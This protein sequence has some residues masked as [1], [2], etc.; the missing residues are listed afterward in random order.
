MI[1]LFDIVQSWHRIQSTSPGYVIK[2]EIVFKNSRLICIVVI[3]NRKHN[4]HSHLNTK[5]SVNLLINATVIIIATST[6]DKHNLI[7]GNYS[8]SQFRLAK[9]SSKPIKNIL[10]YR[11]YGLLSDTS[12]CF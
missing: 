7:S 2:L 1:V 12:F 11:K 10:D 6:K 4:H 3:V 9:Q 8:Q 5:P